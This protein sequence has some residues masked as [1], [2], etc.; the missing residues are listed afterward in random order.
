MLPAS[1]AYLPQIVWTPNS[2]ALAIQRLDRKQ[3]QLEL[4]LADAA[5]GE[6]KSLLKESDAYWINTDPRG[7]RFLPDGQRFLWT[8]ERTGF[9]HIFLY[10]ITGELESQVT[11]G[12]WAVTSVDAVNAAEV[13]YTAT[14]QSPLERHVYRLS[15]KDGTTTQWTTAHGWH[16]PAIPS[17]DQSRI[18]FPNLILSDQELTLQ[19]PPAG[20]LPIE[21]TTL[22]THDAVTLNAMLIRPPAFDPSKQY[23]AIVLA[24]PGPQQQVVRDAPADDFAQTLARAGFVVFAVDGRGS[25]GRGRRFE[26]PLH[27][28]LGGIEL[29]DQLDALQFLKRQ[30][31]VDMKR[32]GIFGSGYAGMIAL[33]AM[34]HSHG[35]YR[36]AVADAP[37]T[38]WNLVDAFTAERYL[39]PHSPKAIAYSESSPNEFAKRL[40]GPLLILESGNGNHVEALRQ[41]LQQTNMLRPGRATIETISAQLVYRR[42]LRFFQESLR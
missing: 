17:P 19:P 30:R 16:T 40:E 31:F 18:A 22:T 29:P 14:A 36:A 35:I 21:F 24:P 42:A 33:G 4:F 25:G 5:T 32:I 23:P 39:G 9:R 6:A 2:Q 38:D 11:H 27:F 26:E 10:R 12:D 8:S 41:E 20:L 37:I 13:I 7:L 3:T 28:R 15:F 1:E 34:M